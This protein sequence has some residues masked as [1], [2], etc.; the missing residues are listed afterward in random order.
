M[1]VRSLG[2]HYIIYLLDF[3]VPNN[4]DDI[5]YNDNVYSFLQLELTQFV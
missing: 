4:N 1:Q 3:V 2:V 5:Y